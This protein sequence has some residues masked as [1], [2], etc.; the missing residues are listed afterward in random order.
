MP[1]KSLVE[2]K[3]I[4][5]LKKNKILNSTENGDITCYL[6]SVHMTVEFPQMTLCEIMLLM[7]STG[8]ISFILVDV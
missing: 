4:T 6:S 2:K 3:N 7:N 8:H 1:L 5:F